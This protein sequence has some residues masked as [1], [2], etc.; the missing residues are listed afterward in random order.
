[1]NCCDLRWDF[2]AP[3]IM[4]TLV[5]GAKVQ[6][7]MGQNIILCNGIMSFLYDIHEKCRSYPVISLSLRH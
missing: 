3:T 4:M 6:Q 5:D 7:N 2:I 1:M